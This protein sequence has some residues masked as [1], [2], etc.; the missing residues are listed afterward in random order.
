MRP[1]EIPRA[2]LRLDSRVCMRKH[3]HSWT[4]PRS[5]GGRSNWPQ[6]RPGSRRPDPCARALSASNTGTPARK[7]EHIGSSA[8]PTT[9]AAVPAMS[10][11]TSCPKSGL[12]LQ[13]LS[14]SACWS[15]SASTSR[16]RSPIARLNCAAHPQQIKPNRRFRTRHSQV[17]VAKHRIGLIDI[18][19]RIFVPIVGQRFEQCDDFLARPRPVDGPQRPAHIAGAVLERSVQPRR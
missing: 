16:S 19:C 10:A 15:I 4:T 2:Y 3:P 7:P 12:S 6:P 13:T 14:A 1:P 5:V 8:T 17:T 9:C 18:D 11:Q